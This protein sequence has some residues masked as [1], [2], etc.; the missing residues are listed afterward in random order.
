MN[1][2]GNLVAAGFTETTNHCWVSGLEPDTEYIYRVI[3]NDEEWAGGNRRNWERVG[4]TMGLGTKS[5]PYKNRFRT[6]P[7]P[8]KS[9]TA[10]FTFAVIGDFGVGIKKD[11]DRGQRQ[12]AEAL[13]KVVDEF[14]VR[15]ILTT[16]DNI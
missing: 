6:H 9:S 1:L 16:G 7:D 3:V 4:D 15:L 14:N 10:P 12:I 11:T 5:R 2:A 13:E 8:T